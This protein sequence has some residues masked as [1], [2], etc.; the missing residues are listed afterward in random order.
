MCA[1]LRRKT[2][3]KVATKRR[4]ARRYTK[5]ID[6]S[7]SNYSHQSS[8][9]SVGCHNLERITKNTPKMTDEIST[10]SNEIAQTFSEIEPVDQSG[11]FAY[12][13]NI[14]TLDLS[15]YKTLG[16]VNM[17]SMFKYCDR[18][19]SINFH[20]SQVP[21]GHSFDTSL[22]TNM[23]SMFCGCYSITYLDLSNFDVSKVTNMSHMFSSC[24]S[25]EVVKLTNFNTSKVTNMNHM[26]SNCA[27]LV[28]LDL[29]SFDTSRVKNMNFMFENCYKLEF[30]N[31]G[32]NFKPKNKT[33]MRDMFKNCKSLCEIYIASNNV[34]VRGCFDDAGIMWKRAMESKA[35]YPQARKRYRK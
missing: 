7:N 20:A 2:R 12:L 11:A 27:S 23:H 10:K 13:D 9:T 14:V 28:H 6:S 31:F 35:S 29:S 5:R 19:K 32:N 1:K 30:I 18:L 3:T 25:L 21:S 17:D 33:L 26:F 8:D 34:D 16:S 4:S 22:V 15:D 24:C